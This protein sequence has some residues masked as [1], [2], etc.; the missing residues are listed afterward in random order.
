MSTK[1]VTGKARFSYVNVFEPTSMDEGQEK[2]YN[3]SVLI[4]KSDKATL[5]K[6]HAAIEEATQQGLT[7][8]FGGK[9]PAM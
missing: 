9:K 2:K 6:I 5:A 1:I 4:P 7:S 3:L 8:K